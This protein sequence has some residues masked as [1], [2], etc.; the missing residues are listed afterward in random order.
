MC[1]YCVHRRACYAA[2][3]QQAQLEHSAE[4]EPCSSYLWPN[5]SGRLLLAV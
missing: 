4:H 1:V 3:R 5:S 2:M